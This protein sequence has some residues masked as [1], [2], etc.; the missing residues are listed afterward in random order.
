MSDVAEHET[1]PLNCSVSPRP[2]GSALVHRA[3]R[4]VCCDETG[5]GILEFAVSRSASYTA[6]L[7]T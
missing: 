7:T 5:W 4:F 6:W 3:S 1:H 2:L